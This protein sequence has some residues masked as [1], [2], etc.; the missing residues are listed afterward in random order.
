MAPA[1]AP[2]EAFPRSGTLHDR[3]RPDAI[4]HAQPR[5]SIA[6]F[7]AAP[8]LVAGMVAGCGK[9]PDADD[10][11]SPSAGQQDSGGGVIKPH[12]EGGEGGEGSEGGEGGES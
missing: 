10:R 2:L 9:L 6:L 12:D 1:P 8:G 7:L 11:P 4:L 3:Q 5:T